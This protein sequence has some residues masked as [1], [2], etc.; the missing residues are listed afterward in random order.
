M[1]KQ[2]LFISILLTLVIQNVYGSNETS[3]NFIKR[4][5]TFFLSQNIFERNKSNE[6]EQIVKEY[7][8]AFKIHMGG[9]TQDD[10]ERTMERIIY[11]NEKTLEQKLTPAGLKQ[12][13][14]KLKNDK[15]DVA[16]SPENIS[17][18]NR[19]VATQ[20][21]KATIHIQYGKPQDELNQKF[22]VEPEIDIDD[23]AAIAPSTISPCSK[24]SSTLLKYLN[25]NRLNE[26]MEAKS[27][28]YDHVKTYLRKY[29]KHIQNHYRLSSPDPLK[30]LDP[31]ELEIFKLIRDIY[32]FDKYD[33]I[34]HFDGFLP[35]KGTARNHSTAIL[36]MY[37]TIDS[38]PGLLESSGRS[39]LFHGS[40]SSS[41]L[42]FT[43]YG[44]EDKGKLLSTGKLV[45]KDRVPFS[46][47]I[48]FGLYGIS[49]EHIST[50]F[51]DNIKAAM[52]Y[53]GVVNHD[54]SWEFYGINDSYHQNKFKIEDFP[55][56]ATRDVL[57]KR[58]NQW[59]DLNKKEQ[60]LVN[61]NF[62][63]MYGLK[64]N[65]KDYYKAKLVN[66]D[67]NSEIAVKSPIDPEIIK[68][69]YV[70]KDHLQQTKELLIDFPDINVASFESLNNE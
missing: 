65:N 49:R 41:L 4:I 38:Y 46:G 40:K 61:L 56:Q 45:E 15:Y 47:E 66:S 24:K 20:Y 36:S 50:V 39:I 42:A 48:S 27:Y 6:N 13:V 12:V 59:S 7:Y 34:F 19:I 69:I 22:L 60:T 64:P 54:K 31:I 2:F 67:I 51:V 18:F 63:V 23:F 26:I 10:F 25:L 14:R 29:P 21:L 57:E 62:P 70:P 3:N 28:R 35:T 1:S 17:T 68:V 53:A 16:L 32:Q 55:L 44:K 52:R 11:H 58:K 8:E 9:K 43:D 30:F 37:R 33:P 5:K